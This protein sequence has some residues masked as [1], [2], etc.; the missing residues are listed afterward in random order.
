M[1]NDDSRTDPPLTAGEVETSLGFLDYHRDTLMMKVAGLDRAQLAQTLAPSPMTLAGLVKHLA[2]VEESWFCERLAGR[3][4]AEPWASVDWDADE[5]WDWHSA[6]DDEP[7]ALVTQWE[8]S[9]AMARECADEAMAGGGFEQVTVKPN[10]RSEHFSMRWIVTHMIEEYARHNGH[11][12]MIRES[13][14]GQTGE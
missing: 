9:V 3:D 5:D 11:A 7:D 10:R 2:L 8:R 4:P 13:I 1:T 6:V 12:D 14:D